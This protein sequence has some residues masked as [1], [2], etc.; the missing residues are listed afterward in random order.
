MSKSPQGLKADGYLIL[1]EWPVEYK[2]FISIKK[3]ICMS[4]VFDGGIG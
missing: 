2:R 4:L 1:V 3:G